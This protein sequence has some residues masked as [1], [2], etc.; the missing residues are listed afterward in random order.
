[1]TM[2]SS[3]LSLQT[4]I[5]NE[6]VVAKTETL[7]TSRSEVTEVKRSLQVLEIELQSQFSLVSVTAHL[8][9]CCHTQSIL[10][11]PPD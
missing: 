5:L 10:S 6:E 2:L 3:S 8:R 11:P 7:Q 9:T 1:M 4:E